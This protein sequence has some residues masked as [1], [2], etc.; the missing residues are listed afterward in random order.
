MNLINK[1]NYKVYNKVY[2]SLKDAHDYPNTNLVRIVRWRLDRG[3]KLLDYGF[4]YGENSIFLSNEGYDVY[5]AE[6]SKKIINYATDKSR[7]KCKKKINF[8]HINPNMKKLPFKDNYFNHIICLGVIQYLGNLENTKN[9]FQEFYRCLKKNGKIIVS[10]FGPQN[11][12]IRR[13]KKIDKNTYLFR[14]LEKFHSKINLS[15]QIYIPENKKNFKEFFPKGLKVEEVGSWSN[16]YCGINGF[17]Y[18]AI[19]KKIE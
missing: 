10:T 11:T 1:K 4:G 12:F 17:H 13:S 8:F 7:K 6:I 9:L 15:Y 14:G 3:G 19:G 18:V 2:S 5:A 16:D